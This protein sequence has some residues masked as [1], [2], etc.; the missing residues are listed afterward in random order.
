[1]EWVTRRQALAELSHDRGKNAPDVRLLHRARAA[2]ALADRALDPR[3][4][5]EL[6]A[7][8]VIELARLAIHAAFAAQ[9]GEAKETLSEQWAAADAAWLGGV[10][11]G[12]RD[13]LRDLVL[14]SRFSDLA[15]LDESA[16]R[17]RAER[18]V[19]FARR[20]VKSLEA[21]DEPLL[22]A[23][24]ERVYRVALVLGVLGILVALGVQGVVALRRGPDLASGKPWQAS[25]ALADC[26]LGEDGICRGRSLDIFFHTTIQ[27]NPWVRFDLGAATSFSKVLLVNR[28]D[29]CQER[30]VPLVVEVSDDAKTYRQVAGRDRPFSKILLSFPPTTARYLRLRVDKKTA[31]HLERVSVYR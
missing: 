6:A 27:E 5:S 10:V 29:C 23:R 3:E 28:S 9:A 13:E 25:S 16:L 21:R 11:E 7:L 14:E 22:R 26:P 30:A 1:M 8:P 12:D 24:F 2:L 18:A 19:A 31:L 15:A 4:A 17:A 20:L